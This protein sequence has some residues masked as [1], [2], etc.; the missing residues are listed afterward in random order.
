M[1]DEPGIYDMDEATY[2]ADPCADISLRSSIASKL[3]DRGSTPR[4]AWFACP[5]LNPDFK[6]DNRRMFDL[7]KACHASLLGKGSK[8]LII[9]DDSYRSKMAKELRDAA[10]AVG[11]IPL[12]E[13]EAA[14]VFEMA[15]AARQQ[16][17]DLVA[18]GTL[19]RMP[20]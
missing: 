11:E 6:P 18:A 5:R 16:L 10:Y 12:L 2:N 17:G 9:K 8:L 20:E 4:H 15:D 19:S 14:Q 1:I 7:G 3:V 13:Y